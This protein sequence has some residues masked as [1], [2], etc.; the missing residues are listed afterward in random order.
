MYTRH[1]TGHFGDALGCLSQKQIS[2]GPY[3]YGP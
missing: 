1:K 2:I 3:P